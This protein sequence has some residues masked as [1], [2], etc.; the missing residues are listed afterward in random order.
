[1]EYPSIDD[2]LPIQL[3]KERILPYSLRIDPYPPTRSIYIY[4]YI[5]RPIINQ[6]EEK[7]ARPR[8]YRGELTFGRIK[9]EKERG[10]RR[11]P[12]GSSSLLATPRGN[13]N[14]GNE[15]RTKGG[16]GEGR[17]RGSSLHKGIKVHLSL[18]TKRRGEGKET[19][20]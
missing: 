20:K 3:E 2:R 7:G 4:I 12:A 17:G 5:N 15:E 6:S 13:E 11:G 14:L 16:G 19:A 18:G 8:G 9:R 1:M 10:K